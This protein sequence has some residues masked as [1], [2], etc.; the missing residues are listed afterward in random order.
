VLYGSWGYAIRARLVKD[1]IPTEV[2]AAICRRIV[3][4]QSLYAVGAF[5]CIFNPYWSIAFIVLVQLNYAIAPRL[6]PLLRKSGSSPN[7]Q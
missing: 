5:L 3:T 7:P 6:R 1:D 4:G 2:P